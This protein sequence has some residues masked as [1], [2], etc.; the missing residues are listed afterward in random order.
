MK[1]MSCNNKVYKKNIWKNE[2][3]GAKKENKYIIS[4]KTYLVAYGLNYYV[5]FP[6][7]IFVPLD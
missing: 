1:K 5:T 7:Y 4:L 3:E 2:T 6:N